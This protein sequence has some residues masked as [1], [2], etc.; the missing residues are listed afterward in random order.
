MQINL[1]SNLSNWQLDMS[2]FCWIIII[3][4]IHSNQEVVAA[5]THIAQVIWW[6]KGL[7]YLWGTRVLVLIPLLLCSLFSMAKM[8]W[9]K[10]LKLLSLEIEKANGWEENLEKRPI[11]EKR[12][13]N[14]D[15][16]M[17]TLEIGAQY[18]IRRW[19]GLTMEIPKVRQ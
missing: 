18:W 9:T 4:M 19:G 15:P 3:R 11:N 5:S 8:S 13:L 14:K 7:S 2:S 1:D 10:N 12:C 16:P 6:W 17:S